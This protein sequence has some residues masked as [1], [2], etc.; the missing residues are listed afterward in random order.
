M[1]KATLIGLAVGMG[2]GLATAWTLG[3]TVAYVALEDLRALA[4]DAKQRMLAL[5]SGT[6]EVIDVD[7]VE[8]AE[9]QS[10]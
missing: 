6:S 3:G 1:V 9:G 8:I 5:H 7:S 10:T 2:L 4:A